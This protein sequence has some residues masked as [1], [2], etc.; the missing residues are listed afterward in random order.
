MSTL[1]ACAGQHVGVRELARGDTAT[2]LA[3]FEGLSEAQRVLRF[4][5]GMTRLPPS[6]L[7]ALAD[8]DGRRHVAL[9]A[10]VGGRPVGIARYHLVDPPAAECAVEVVD[11]CTGLGIG[12][13]LLEELRRVALRR[14][15][16][17]VSV[18]IAATNARAR[19]LARRAGVELRRDADTLVGAV[20]VGSVPA[21]W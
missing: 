5:T 12:R 14:G 16:E 17:Q 19:R 20:L 15:V 3:V 10:E 18:D 21:L 11:R 9:V 13:R 8:L 4:R 7:T 2:V 6:Y 1:D